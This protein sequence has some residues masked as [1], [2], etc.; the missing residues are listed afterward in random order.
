M[1]MLWDEGIP[2]SVGSAATDLWRAL[3]TALASSRQ[4]KVWPFEGDLD[5]LLQAC[6]HRG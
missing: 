4:F 6:G 2:G 1:M 5:E 3:G